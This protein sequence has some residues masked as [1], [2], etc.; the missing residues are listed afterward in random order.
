MLIV[1]KIILLALILLTSTSL[2][3]APLVLQT[4]IFS[5]PGMDA[6]TPW[7]RYADSRATG[8]QFPVNGTSGPMLYH[9]FVMRLAI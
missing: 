5:M 1:K 4:N 6:P 9:G 7:L 2:H 3:A 8:V